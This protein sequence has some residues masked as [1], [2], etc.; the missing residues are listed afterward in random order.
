MKITFRLSLFLIQ[1]SLI[2]FHY[3]SSDHIVKVMS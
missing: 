2:T 1:Y 3:D